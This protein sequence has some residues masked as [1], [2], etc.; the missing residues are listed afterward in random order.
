MAQSLPTQQPC[1]PFCTSCSTSKALACT[2]HYACPTLTPQLPLLLCPP[3]PEVGHIKVSRDHGLV[4]YTLPHQEGA[5]TQ[6]A[7]IRAAAGGPV[8]YVVP[9]V[10]NIEWLADSRHLVFTVPDDK[11]R[12]WQVS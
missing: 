12:P 4:A 10:M 11:G 8:L 6:C 2:F 5:D 9:S 1:S 3:G 7:I